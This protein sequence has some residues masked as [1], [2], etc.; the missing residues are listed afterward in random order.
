MAYSPVG[1]GGRLLRNPAL[2]TVAARHGVTPAQVAIAWSL[3]HP[4]VISIPKSGDSAHVRE[5]A[6]AGALVLSPADLADIDR[7]Y[8]PPIRRQS[9]AML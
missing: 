5:N 3:R 4:G 6:A 8:K 2:K 9:L 7:A 1:Q